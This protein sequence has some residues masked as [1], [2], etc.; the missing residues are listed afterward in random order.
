MQIQ[1]INSNNINFNGLHV[2]KKTLKE[3]GCTRKELLANS[4]IREASEKYDVLIKAGRGERYKD[5][6]WYPLNTY[7]RTIS[8]C[9]GTGILTGVTAMLA[10]DMASLGVGWFTALCSIPT[11]AVFCL[12]MLYDKHKLKPVKE[13]VIQAGKGV[14][15]NED[16][17]KNCSTREH[18]LKYAQ[19]EIPL[20]KEV[21]EAETRAF[22][23]KIRTYDTNDLFS[24]KKYLEALKKA[25]IGI[26]GGGDFFNRPIDN[27]GNTML[28][29][30]F[31]V[32]PT[33]ETMEEYK[34]ILNILARTKGINYNQKDGNGISCIE[35][36]INSENK[37]VLPLIFGQEFDYS[38]EVE[39][40]YNHIQDTNFKYWFDNS[41][42]KFNFVD[43]LQAVKLKSY[44]VLTRLRPQL[45]SPLCDRKRLAQQIDEILEAN[46]KKSSW[47]RNW[48]SYDLEGEY[49][50]R[51][52]SE[53]I[54][55]DLVVN[56]N[57]WNNLVDEKGNL[58]MPWEKG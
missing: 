17:I 35:K 15:A 36:V 13:I 54:N 6:P 28:T 25:D 4:S 48:R 8:T 21:K 30:F 37:H 33:E 7:Y 27:Q 42:L 56:L 58:L 32:I 55:P 50:H 47:G 9:M 49:I 3:I 24:A 40:L 16:Y 53:Y 22:N 45:N 2:S 39:I 23:N 43:I 38:N 14:D 11:F 1:S 20:T 52:Y 18:V 10:T 44:H 29:Q 19:T 57:E 31:D 12:N 41:D 46:S 34:E 5:D 51:Y 26:L